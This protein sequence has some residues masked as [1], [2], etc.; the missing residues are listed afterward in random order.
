M[1]E[2]S[3][4][5][6]LSLFH[7]DP[8]SRLAAKLH[9]LRNGWP[10]LPWLASFAILVSYLVPAALARMQGFLSG[11]TTRESFLLD[12]NFPVQVMAIIILFAAER[13]IDSEE[14]FDVRFG[15]RQAATD[16]R[17]PIS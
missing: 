13:A 11:P 6:T 16:A 3:G 9:L 12:I 8:F 10:S 1:N 5:S 14:R 17:E 2:M 4:H 7:N 15:G